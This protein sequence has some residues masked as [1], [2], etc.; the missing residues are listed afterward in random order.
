MAMRARGL[1]CRMPSGQ[2]R[3]AGSYSWYVFL[4]LLVPQRLRLVLFDRTA[5]A[6]IAGQ[7]FGRRRSGRRPCVV[8]RR[9]RHSHAAPHDDRVARLRAGRWP[10]AASVVLAF[11]EGWPSSSPVFWARRGWASTTRAGSPRR[12]SPPCAPTPSSSANRRQSSSW[13]GRPPTTH[14]RAPCR[15]HFGSF[16]AGL[17]AAGSS[18]EGPSSGARS[19]SSRRWRVRARNRLLATIHRLDRGLRGLASCRHRVPPLRRLAGSPEG[20]KRECGLGGLAAA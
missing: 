15:R 6:R 11:A 20:C 17:R 7:I 14:P 3:Q 12:S 19:R 4:P 16:T 5:V 8:H 9:A 13:N 2:S 1:R 18:R 10:P